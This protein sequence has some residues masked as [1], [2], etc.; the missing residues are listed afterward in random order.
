MI[1]PINDIIA[2][3]SLGKYIVLRDNLKIEIDELEK[4]PCWKALQNS[5]FGNEINNWNIATL[6]GHECTHPPNEPDKKP[7]ETFETLNENEIKL[8]VKEPTVSMPDGRT[9]PPTD[10]SIV[11][12]LPNIV[13]ISSILVDLGKLETIKLARSLTYRFD[14][15]IYQWE[16]LRSRMI[17]I[18]MG[19]T[20]TGKGTFTSSD[21]KR[22]KLYTEDHKS[23]SKKALFK[24][25]TI[26]DV[27]QLAAYKIPNANDL[28]LLVRD[29]LKIQLPSLNPIEYRFAIIFIG[30]IMVLSLFYF[31]MYQREAQYSAYYPARGTLF[32]VFNQSRL[33]KLVFLLLTLVPPVS[34]ILLAIYSR[35]ITYISSVSAALILILSICIAFESKMY[36][37]KKANNN[38][39]SNR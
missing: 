23:F 18:N 26:N 28:A 33:T 17:T 25:L 12:Q 15:Q 9:G 36:K 3:K 31:L 13:A 8:R 7:S 5:K 16:L 24:Y 34:S 32:G 22:L 20:P 1:K 14:T 2:L 4:D 19:F 37:M 30:V 10:L 11:Y 6:L 21:N 39:V 38:N 29:K 27:K 35:S